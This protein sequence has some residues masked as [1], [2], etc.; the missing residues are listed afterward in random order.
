MSYLREQEDGV[1]LSVHA[2]PRASRTSLV[3]LHGEALKIAVRA[4]PMEGEANEALRE[5]LA[6]LFGVP[7]SKV[8]LRRGEKSREKVFIVRGL[9]L[10]E[11]RAKIDAELK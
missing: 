3:G 10:E 6:E 5:Y 8:E 7:R 11:A 1:L 4:L 2:Q 9:K